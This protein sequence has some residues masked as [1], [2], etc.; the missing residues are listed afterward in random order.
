MHRHGAQ[1][2]PHKSTPTHQRYRAQ[3]TPINRDGE[4]NAFCGT[5]NTKELL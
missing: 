5:G 3:P 1:P 2:K 4:T